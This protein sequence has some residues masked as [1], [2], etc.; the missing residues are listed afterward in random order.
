M[1]GSGNQSKEV[2]IEGVA[3]DLRYHRNGKEVFIDGLFK[4]GED[5]TD[6]VDREALNRH[7]YLLEVEVE[8]L[9]DDVDERKIIETEQEEPEIKFY[10]NATTYNE[11]LAHEEAEFDNQQED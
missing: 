5:H 9:P 2:V 7:I 3:Y 10:R 6:K 8:S 4:Y 1:N 11:R